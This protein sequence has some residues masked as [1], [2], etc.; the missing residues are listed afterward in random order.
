[1]YGFEVLGLFESGMVS[2]LTTTTATTALNTNRT[3]ST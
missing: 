2:E 3:I 1:M